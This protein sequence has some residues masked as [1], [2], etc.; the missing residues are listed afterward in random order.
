[1]NERPRTPPDPIAT[2]TAVVERLEKDAVA[3]AR[4]RT[5]LA[6]F[7]VK[8]A[9]DR[10]TLA[11]IRTTLTMATFGFGLAAFFRGVREAHPQNPEATRLQEGAIKMGMALLVLGIVATALAGTSH[12]FALRRLRR[13]EMPV[14]THWPLSITVAVLLTGFGLAGVYFLLIGMAHSG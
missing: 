7:R 2:E 9:L 12:W 11:W 4:D 3:L 6:S 8:L 10:T 5:S 1:M 13:G 14:L